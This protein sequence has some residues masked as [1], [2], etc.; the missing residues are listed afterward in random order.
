MRTA[1]A[2]RA[3][4]LARLP[5]MHGFGTGPESFPSQAGAQVPFLPERDGSGMRRAACWMGS[6]AATRDALPPLWWFVLVLL[7]LGLTARTRPLLNV[8]LVEF[9]VVTS[10]RGITNVSHHRAMIVPNVIT[11]PPALEAY[12]CD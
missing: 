3:R 7:R 9:S 12:L 8:E 10:W 5:S 4:S 11:R 6:A 1:P 2:H